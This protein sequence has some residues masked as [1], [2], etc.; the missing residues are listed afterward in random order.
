MEKGKKKANRSRSGPLFP[1]FHVLHKSRIH[2]RNI[3]DYER[4]LACLREISPRQEI[5]KDGIIAKAS[6]MPVHEA[7]RHK[8]VVLQLTDNVIL[9]AFFFLFLFLLFTLLLDCVSQ[10]CN[11]LRKVSN[12][13]F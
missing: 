1:S 4:L 2:V 7:A 6:A 5:H 12:L 11:L 13:V 8:K 10:A 3:F 9:P